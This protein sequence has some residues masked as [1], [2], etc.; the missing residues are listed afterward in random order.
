LVD[1]VYYVVEIAVVVK[2][3][4]GGTVGEGKLVSAP[5]LNYVL[6]GEVAVVFVDV[7]TDFF[8]GVRDWRSR[9]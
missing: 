1:I 3:G 7:V 5:F 2:V 9:K 4:V 6:E 8:G